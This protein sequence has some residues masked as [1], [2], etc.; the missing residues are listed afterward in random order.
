MKIKNGILKVINIMWYA[1]K[2]YIKSIFAFWGFVFFF[3]NKS[4]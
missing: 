4:T 2:L 3:S 1:V